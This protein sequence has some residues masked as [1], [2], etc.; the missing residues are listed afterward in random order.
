MVALNKTVL[1]VLFLMA[2]LAGNFASAQP[3]NNVSR[4][5][6]THADGGNTPIQI[7]EI[8]AIEEGRLLDV[9]VANSGATAVAS[10]TYGSGDR[11]GAHHVI[12]GQSTPGRDSLANYYHSTGTA[13]D[14]LI[15]T[16]AA[17]TSLSRLE[18]V[19]RE[20]CCLNRDRYSVQLQNAAGVPLE[21]IPL[22]VPDA[23]SRRASVLFSEPPGPDVVG[24][25][26]AVKP[27]PLV[28]VS[29]ANL[30]L[31]ANIQFMTIMATKMPLVGRG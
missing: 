18:I 7:S 6:V 3:I 31:E 24:E 10:G 8:I 13:A 2:T 30:P 5:V 16:L 19:G 20:D 4:I 26:G 22:I 23:V 25:W 12:D 15:V 27:W 21:V 9:A 14:S 11:Y 29:M 1:L 28:A 17:P